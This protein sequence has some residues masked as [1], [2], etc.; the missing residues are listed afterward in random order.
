MAAL[1]LPEEPEPQAVT[2]LADDTT[3]GVLAVTGFFCIIGPLL[4]L[5]AGLAAGARPPHDD[6]DDPAR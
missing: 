6:D 1:L 4:V 2:I 5:L 3:V